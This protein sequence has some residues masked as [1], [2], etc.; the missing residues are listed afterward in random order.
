M[1]IGERYSSMASRVR[2]TSTATAGNTSS[3]PMVSRSTARS[4]NASEL[5]IRIVIGLEADEVGGGN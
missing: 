1:P 4:P 2:C 5:P 3:T